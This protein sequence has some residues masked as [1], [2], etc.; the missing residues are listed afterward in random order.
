M[1]DRL[2]THPSRRVGRLHKIRP[3]L[4]VVP[5]VT[6]GGVRTPALHVLRD[7]RPAASGAALPLHVSAHSRREHQV[8]LDGPLVVAGGA[9]CLPTLGAY[10]LRLW[11][12]RGKQLGTQC[13]AAICT[14]SQV[15]AQLGRGAREPHRR[16]PFEHRPTATGN[17][18]DPSTRPLWLHRAD[19]ASKTTCSKHHPSD[20]PPFPGRM[21]RRT[22]LRRRFGQRRAVDQVQHRIRNCRVPL[23]RPDLHLPH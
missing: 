7:I 17:A 15:E 12:R 23:Q 13:C 2:W 14:Q 19:P 4:H 22:C 18:L 21:M 6:A 20:E 10:P 8:V 5:A 9:W 11:A 1:S 3:R 16:Q